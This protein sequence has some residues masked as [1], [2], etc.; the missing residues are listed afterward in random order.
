M[1]TKRTNSDATTAIQEKT[2]TTKMRKFRI[3]S[4]KI[5]FNTEYS[6]KVNG[7]VLIF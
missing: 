7:K 2:L 5:L 4:I 6:L 3:S 1:A